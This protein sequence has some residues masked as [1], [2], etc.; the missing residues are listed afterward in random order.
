MA[1]AVS[2]ARSWGLEYTRV[3]GRFSMPFARQAACIF[4]VSLRGMS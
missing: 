3:T 4:P 1:L 2:R